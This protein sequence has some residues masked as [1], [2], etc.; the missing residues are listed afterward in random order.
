MARSRRVRSTGPCSRCS[1][2]TCRPATAVHL[3]RPA[4]RAAVLRPE[5]CPPVAIGV[6]R[7]LRAAERLMGD[8]PDVPLLNRVP[9]RRGPQQDSAKAPKPG[10]VVQ[11]PDRQGHQGH[12][13]RC[14]RRPSGLLPARQHGGE[15]ILCVSS[16]A[17]TAE[18][19]GSCR[20]RRRTPNRTDVGHRFY[21]FSVRAL[22]GPNPV[23]SHVTRRPERRRP[24]PHADPARRA[25]ASAEQAGDLHRYLGLSRERTGQRGFGRSGK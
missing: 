19:V 18:R 16:Q 17:S 9:R 22:P 12:R 10:R 6:E 4:A 11:N 1:A 20:T 24:T 14:T 2:R 21:P 7:G 13:G 15:R 5:F 23:S 8:G 25:P 3:D